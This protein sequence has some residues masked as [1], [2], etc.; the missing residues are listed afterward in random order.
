MKT[1][2]LL[3]ILRKMAAACCATEAAMISGSALSLISS[4]QF[5]DIRLK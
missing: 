4:L 5:Q 2:E 3:K 1:Q